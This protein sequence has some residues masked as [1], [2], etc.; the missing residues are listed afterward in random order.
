MYFL[1]SCFSLSATLHPSPFNLFNLKMV[2]R[3]EFMCCVCFV[4]VLNTKKVSCSNNVIWLVPYFSSVH[5]SRSVVSD[6]LQPH[7]SARQASLSITISR[8]SLK[9]T[10][11]ESCK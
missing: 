11:I 6:S 2:L 10:S 8:S 4:G 5:F 3:K 7:E 9:L 1:I